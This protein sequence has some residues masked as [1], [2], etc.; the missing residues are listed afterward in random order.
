MNEEL[1]TLE[2][3]DRCEKIWDHI[4]NVQDN[5][6]KLAKELI[7]LG[8]HKLARRLYQRG[9]Q[10]DASKFDDTEYYGMYSSDETYKKIAIHTHRTMNSHHL[11]Y[12]PELLDLSTV[13]ICEMVCDLKARSSEFG[14]DI[15]E[16]IRKFTEER[17][18]STNTKFYKLLIK[19]LNLIL[20]DKFK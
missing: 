6:Q 3:L 12:H 7:K 4:Q 14:T 2:H 5:I 8:E 16:Y 10:H 11:E 15:K 17:N 20:E 9:L 1:T 18:I 19:Y 13:D